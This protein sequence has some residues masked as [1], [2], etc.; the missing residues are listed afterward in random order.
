MQ[1]VLQEYADS[2]VRVNAEQAPKEVHKNFI[3]AIEM[4]F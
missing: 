1:H 3:E 2:I 4:T